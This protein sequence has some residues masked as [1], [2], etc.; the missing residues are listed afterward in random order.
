MLM[1]RRS[2]SWM[3][4]RLTLA[5][6]RTGALRILPS[7]ISRA[8]SVDIAPRDGAAVARA[9]GA[10]PGG[11]ADL[12]RVVAQ[13]ERVVLRVPGEGAAVDAAAEEGAAVAA[14]GV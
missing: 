7:R 14:R 5:S 11:D 4:R 1:R 8:W 3:H 13:G 2:R 12:R 9:R 10:R 6:S